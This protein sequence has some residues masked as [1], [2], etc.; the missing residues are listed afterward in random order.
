MCSL[1]PGSRMPAHPVAFAK[2]FLHINGNIKLTGVP[3]SGLKAGWACSSLMTPEFKK[4]M[5][6]SLP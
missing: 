5:K 4:V 6:A 3:F 2:L 1:S